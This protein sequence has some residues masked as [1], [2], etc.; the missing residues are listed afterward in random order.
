LGRREYIVAVARDTIEREHARIQLEESETIRKIAECAKDAIIMMGP[1]GEI[2]FWNT[3]AER[4]FG[5]S[6]NEAIGKHLHSLLAPGRF[7]DAYQKG[8][9]YFQKT[10]KGDA[11]GKTLKLEAI[12]KNGEE[13]GIELSVNSVYLGG[14]WHAVGIIRD[15]SESKETEADWANKDKATVVTGKSTT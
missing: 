9:S 4:I 7:R 10:G 15:I 3:A 6:R 1:K 2:S 12:R 8:L 13:F 5:Y 11:L 14:K